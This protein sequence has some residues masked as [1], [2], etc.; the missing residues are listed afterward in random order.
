MN[1]FARRLRRERELRS[2]SQEQLAERIGTT[3]PNVGRWERGQTLPGP[4]F[5]QQLCTIFDVSAEDLGLFQEERENEPLSNGNEVPVRSTFPWCLPYRRNPFFTGRDEVLARLH[6]QLHTGNAAILAQVQAI[7]GLG[8]IGKTSTAV[9]YAYRYRQEYQAVLWVHAENHETL[10]ADAVGIAQVLDLPEKD[11]QDLRYVREAVKRW[12]AINQG[13]LLILDNVEEFSIL[14]ELL[15]SE[16][17]GHV[18][19][20][21]RA[22]S[23]GLFAQ[24]IDLE[25]MEPDEGVLFLLRRA[26]V[27]AK[28]ISFE[29]IPKDHL[30]IAREICS[31]MDGLPLAL[32]QAGAYIEETGCSLSECLQRYRGQRAMLLNVRGRGSDSHPQSVSATVSLSIEKL[33]REHPAAAELLEFCAFLHPDAIPEEIITRGAAHLGPVLAPMAD[34]PFRRDA[35]I[36]ALRQYSLIRRN[37]ATK[38]LTV[39]R[40]VQAVV[41]DRMSEERQR[42]WAERAVEAVREVFPKFLGG[43]AT[44]IW[45]HLQRYVLH[46]Q[47]CVS[48]IEQWELISPSAGRLLG[49][50]G[51]YFGNCGEYAQAEIMLQRALDITMPALGP[52]HPDV[53]KNLFDL[54]ELHL[55][56][57]RYELA[58]P[59]FQ[60]ALAIREKVLGPE[61]PEVLESLS[62]LALLYHYKGLFV[63]GELL[64]K[65]AVEI[66]KRSSEPSGVAWVLLHNLGCLYLTESKYTEAEQLLTL[67]L[68][69]AD[70]TPGLENPAKAYIFDHLAM[71]ARERG[72]YPQAEQL[73]Q[74]AFS[75]SEQLPV[76]GFL[77]IK[78]LNDGARLSY[79][80]GKYL[81]GERFCSRALTICE[82]YFGAECEH[83]LTAQVCTNLAMTLFARGRALEAESFAQRALTI[84][85]HTLGVEH[86]KV[87]RSLLVLAGIYLYR[88]E[89]VQAETL[90]RRA[91]K[92][93]KRALGPEN[94]RVAEALNG[95]ALVLF[96]QGK[97]AQAEEVAQ[98][99]LHI[100]EKLCGEMHPYTAQ[101]LHTLG[102]IA[103]E[104]DRYEQAEEYY[105][106]AMYIREQVPGPSHPD[107]AATLDRYA[108]L[109]RTTHRE[110]AACSLAERAQEVR[111]RHAAENMPTEVLAHRNQLSPLTADTSRIGRQ[112]VESLLETGSIDA[113]IVSP[114][115][116]SGP[117]QHA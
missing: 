88:Q 117:F 55:N 92:L 45:N 71:V 28:P 22:Q 82:Q 98:N 58:E 86:H 80:Q 3:A 5:R 38:V 76:A 20:T 23:T 2:W 63:Q 21:T 33:A 61:H 46:V 79:L 50:A 4:H 48:F 108:D 69:V 39:H 29:S 105:R 52:E 24:R 112:E 70:E 8:G 74:R 68:H 115:T 51:V 36:A 72:D 62:S 27:T 77:A 10:T 54:A 53:A 1:D 101:S 11:E 19:M 49:H 106:R 59:L 43:D 6:E 91:L 89:N 87:A 12:L 42:Q 81:R 13:W 97:Y 102:E 83:P 40:L 7:S 31:L 60:Q 64:Y 34:D 93:Y 100:R 44:F 56:R 14:N 67:S 94:P 114:P 111:A 16:S 17:K 15:P 103:H 35:A 116:P 25:R 104:Q 18:L 32:D 110:Q 26:K 107:L 41:K 109:L 57:A 99:S 30:T 95:L 78:T 75:L 47:I 37:P 73:F 9:E 66:W 85:E 96:A 65:R 90:Y 84:R 113:S